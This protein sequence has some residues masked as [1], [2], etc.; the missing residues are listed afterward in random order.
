MEATSS[1]KSSRTVLAA[2]LRPGSRGVAAAA[3]RLKH[4]LHVAAADRAGG[5]HHFAL[6]ARIEH[7]RGENA[8]D[9]QQLIR[10]LR[11]DG[12]RDGVSTAEIA[13]SLR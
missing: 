12:P 11:G 6:R 2:D 4:H 10:G 1:R 9:V 13:I 7:E 8:G 5:D 3:E